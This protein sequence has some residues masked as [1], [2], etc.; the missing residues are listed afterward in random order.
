M[1][2]VGYCVCLPLLC[3]LF[4]ATTISGCGGGG[5]GGN[6]PGGS[7]SWSFK[8]VSPGGAWGGARAVISA[9]GKH[10]TCP[11]GGDACIVF[12][13]GLPW[14]NPWSRVE[15][16]KPVGE[17]KCPGVYKYTVHV[18]DCGNQSHEG[19]P[20]WD[21]RVGF[22]AGS[23]V[24]TYDLGHGL[25]VDGDS[26]YESGWTCGCEGTLGKETAVVKGGFDLKLSVD[27]ASW[28]I[29]GVIVPPEGAK[30]MHSDS[31]TTLPTAQPVPQ[32]DM[33]TVDLVPAEP[34]AD[35]IRPSFILNAGATFIVNEAIVETPRAE[36]RG[37]A[38]VALQ[39]P[40]SKDQIVI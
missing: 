6:S 4:C 20:G 28:K 8:F 17:E 2:K 5:S 39:R 30:A 37:K 27:T 18:S 19:T 21:D 23:D 26:C 15:D 32:H 38:S 29:T 36:D 11:V 40:K 10:A 1:E 9:D 35:T 31:P 14:T 16:D 22:V 12:G 33:P 7:C 3:S 25:W 24:Q 34:S 13:E